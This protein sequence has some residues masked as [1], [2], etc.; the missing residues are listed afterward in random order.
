MTV[1][2]GLRRGS[3]RIIRRR[4]A[5]SASSTI[6]PP[7]SSSRRWMRRL[8][9][10]TGSLSSTRHRTWP[11]VLIAGREAIW[12]RYILQGWTYDPEALTPEEIGA[13]VR[14]Y[15]KPGAVRGALSDYRAGAEDVAQDQADAE[16]PI[17]CPT[18]ALWGEDFEL[19]GKMWDVAGIWR[20]MAPDLRT[21]PIP[22]CGHLPHEERPEE[23]NRALLGFLEGWEG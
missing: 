14:A 16:T 9:A 21:V 6:F 7:R 12:L 4:S 1:A 17:A 2:H 13:Y 10:A 20:E 5:A 8:R 15:Q 18:L 23:V 19:V 11:E 3:P 22:R